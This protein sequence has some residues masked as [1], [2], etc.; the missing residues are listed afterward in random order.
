MELIFILTNI[1]LPIVIIGGI[2]FGWMKRGYEFPRTFVT[3]LI[4]NLGA[5]CLIFSG[6][7]KLGD[8]FAQASIFM[9]AAITAISIFLLLAYIFVFFTG[10][11]KRAYVLALYSRNCGN[12]GI[13]LCYFA[14]GDA[15]M[16]LALVFFAISI[17]FQYTIGLGIV[18]GKL[19]LKELSKIT[20]LYGFGLA[21]LFL[22]LDIEPPL[23]MINTANLLGQLTIPLMLMMLGTSLARF[24]MQKSG[25]LILLSVFKIALGFGV[26][27]GVAA[28]FGF[29][30][31]ERNI[32]ILQMSMPVAVFSYML[33]EKYNRDPEEVASMVFMTTLISFISM[34]LLLTWML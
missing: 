5:P 30:G 29:T 15:G 6:L 19:S 4:M 9:L 10:L 8:N 21:L 22:G 24:K 18:H 11:P 1:I 2:G 7:M 20:F 27:Y 28:L 17:F 12:M 3:S 31:L 14:F 16:A 25:K 23:W 13:P 34:P 32:L 33:A 26:G